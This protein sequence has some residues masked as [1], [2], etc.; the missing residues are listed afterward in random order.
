MRIVFGDIDFSGK[1]KHAGIGSVNGHENDIGTECIRM[2]NVKGYY[3]DHNQ[4][5]TKLSRDKSIYEFHLGEEDAHLLTG[6]SASKTVEDFFEG[7]NGAIDV[8]LDPQKDFG[9]WY[10][11]KEAR[12]GGRK[13]APQF[14][15]KGVGYIR[16][17]DDMSENGLAFLSSNACSTFLSTVGGGNKSSTAA[18]RKASASS[19]KPPSAKPTSAKPRRK[20]QRDSSSATACAL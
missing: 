12:S 7:C 13:I 11:Q 14:R 19:H 20:Q 9:G 18:I 5:T 8:I 4:A 1:V 6:S 3:V 17:G 2:R 10:P 15:S 16:L